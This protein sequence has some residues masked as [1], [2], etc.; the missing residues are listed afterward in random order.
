MDL[1]PFDEWNGE[2]RKGWNCTIQK[3][4]RVGMRQKRS[5]H[6]FTLLRDSLK[7]LHSE[8]GGKRS[9]FFF[10]ERHHIEI[11]W[12]RVHRLHRSFVLQPR[13]QI[14]ILPVHQ[15]TVHRLD[16]FVLRSHTHSLFCH[17]RGLIGHSLMAG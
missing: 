12:V 8:G 3:Q 1:R 10:S 4:K 15:H 13:D 9:I 14:G 11:H 5:K 6:C 2:A 17:C 7:G 16:R